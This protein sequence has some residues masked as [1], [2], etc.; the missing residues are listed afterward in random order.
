MLAADRKKRHKARPITQRLVE[1]SKT[2]DY[3]KS[4]NQ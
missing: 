3:R 1:L 4:D 2:T